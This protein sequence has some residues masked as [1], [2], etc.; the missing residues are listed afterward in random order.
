MKGDVKKLKKSSLKETYPVVEEWFRL[1]GWRPFDFQREAWERFYTGEN[2]LINA[3]TGSGK[4]YSLLVPILV[5]ALSEAHANGLQAIWITPIRALAK[6]IEL[7]AKRLFEA[8]A[9]ELSVGVRTGDTPSAERQRQNRQMPTL[10]IT[11]PESLHLLMASKNHRKVLGQVTALVVDEWHELLGSKRGVQVELARAYLKIIC[12]NLRVWG[13]S[14]TVGNMT[15]AVHV[16]L[17]PDDSSKAHVIKSKVQKKLQVETLMPESYERLPWAGHIGVRLAAH[18][19]KVIEE[20]TSTLIFTN[21]RAQCEIWYR[22]LLE[23][24]PNLMGRIAMH[25]SALTK[26]LRNW[27]EDALYEGKLKAV[28]CTSSLDLGVDFRPV[29]AVVQIGGPKGVARFMQRAGRS[30]HAPG[31]TSKIWFLPTHAIEL[32]EA[33]A[34]RSAITAGEIEE[35]QPYLRSFDVLIQF[36]TTLAVGG[37]AD[38]HIIR[39]LLD[40]T[41]AFHSVSDEELN[42]CLRFLTTGGASL[43]AYPEFRKLVLQEGLYHP[44]G[45]TVARRHRMSIGTIV[46]DTM[47]EVKYRRGAR[48][49]FVEEYFAAGM[50][51]GDVFWFAGRSLEVLAVNG[52]RLEVKNT[53]KKTGRIPSWQGGRLPLSSMLAHVFR[54]KLSDYLA[55]RIE[56]V[57]IQHLVPLLELQQERSRLP[58]SNEL[59]MEVL[60]TKEGYHLFVFPFEGRLVH[61]GLASLVAWR[62]GQI[63]PVSFSMAFN[64][65]GFELLTDQPLPWDTLLTHE[66]FTTAGLVSDLAASVNSAELA[67]RKF[68]DIAVISG[69][70]FR[71]YPGQPVK[72]KHLQSSSSL[73]YDVF[74]SYDSQNLLLRQAYDEMLAYQLEIDRFRSALK[75]IAEQRICQAHIEKPTPLA[76]PLMVDRL[77]ERMSSE[78]L[79][80]RIARMQLDYGA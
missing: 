58:Q 18:V 2:G 35:R 4:T 29:D 9:P 3:P 32:V 73:V 77:R 51:E 68:R 75:R 16:L 64:D 43:E 56:D 20:H 60:H 53:K 54:A 21:T 24:D 62:I 19:S 80:D 13:I 76:F 67:R 6:E 36:I 48:I 1:K 65:Y 33:A 12:P 71:G 72:D 46:G 17:G 47:V 66:L 49:G 69:L 57:E 50:R 8:C 63:I 23:A 79:E 11:T 70:L 55:G 44:V 25:H 10:L 37:G 61:E 34:L 78:K 74:E 7:A 15:E 22:Q 42:W 14:A 27:V 38:P 40:D 41:F 39:Q 30:G 45:Q 52:L 5:Q 28:V 59:L 31:A 26:E